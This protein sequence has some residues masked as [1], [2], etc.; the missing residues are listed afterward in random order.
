MLERALSSEYSHKYPG[1]YKRG[2]L[3]QLA[4][5]SRELNSEDAHEELGF[6][7]PAKGKWRA[8]LARL[9]IGVRAYFSKLI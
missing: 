8:Q 6:F 4:D 3:G 1:D 5:L 7:D 9:R 2:A